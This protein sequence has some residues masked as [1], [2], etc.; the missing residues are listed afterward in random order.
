MV[1]VWV[2]MHIKRHYRHLRKL[3][4][5]SCDLTKAEVLTA[6][7]K[8]LPYDN[9][10]ALPYQPTF[11]LQID[12]AH[13]HSLPRAFDQVGLAVSAAQNTP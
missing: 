11:V 8:L 3:A 9:P 1:Q 6:H 10:F 13:S 12:S 2:L 5:N 7:S 4:A